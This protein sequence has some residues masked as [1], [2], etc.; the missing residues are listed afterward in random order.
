LVTTE[1][2]VLMDDEVDI[3]IVAAVTVRHVKAKE[4]DDELHEGRQ[5]N[6]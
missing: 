2:V 1:E 6:R 3:V 5:L 4:V